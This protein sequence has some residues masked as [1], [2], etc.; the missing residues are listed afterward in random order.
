ME[1]HPPGFG[2]NIDP[3]FQ[4]LV[5]DAVQ[6]ELERVEM[7]HPVADDSPLSQLGERFVGWQTAFARGEWIKES[8]KIINGNY[9]ELNLSTPSRRIRIEMNGRDAHSTPESQLVEHL[10]WARIDPSKLP[11]AIMPI[12]YPWPLPSVNRET[13][14]GA[15]ESLRTEILWAS[16]VASH[17]SVMAH[18]DRAYLIGGMI[19]GQ[20]GVGF[21]T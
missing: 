19:T 3:G 16:D 1:L 7:G 11:Q 4:Q 2:E 13:L 5:T 14:W 9:W 21:S 18:A 8:A 17:R 20:I 15:W 10:M 12:H 6:H